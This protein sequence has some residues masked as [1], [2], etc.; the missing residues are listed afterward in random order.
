LSHACEGFIG[1]YSNNRNRAIT[2]RSF[3]QGL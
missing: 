2:I 1:L 3:L